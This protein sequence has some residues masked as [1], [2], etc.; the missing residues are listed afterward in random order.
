M[1]IVTG[2]QRSGTSMLMRCLHLAGAKKAYEDNG[3]TSPRYPYGFFEG[4]QISHEGAI[5]VFDYTQFKSFISPKIIIMERDTKQIEK[6]TKEK[7]EERLIKKINMTELYE[8]AQKYPHIVVNYETFINTPD[9]YKDQFISLLGSYLDF[10]KLK[11]GI[12]KTLF[13]KR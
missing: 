8:E 12:D 13:T 5:K 10:E 6:S 4:R 2:Q 3:N 11:S 1:I 9:V 7:I